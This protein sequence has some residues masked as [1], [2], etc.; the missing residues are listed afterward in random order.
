MT[1][2]LKVKHVPAVGIEA[3]AITPQKIADRTN[4][5]ISE[6]KLWT[7]RRKLKLGQVFEIQEGHQSNWD[8]EILGDTSRIKR[9]GQGMSGGSMLID[10]GAGMHLGNGMKGGSIRVNRNVDSW[11]GCEMVDGSISIGGDA[12]HYIG[13]AYRGSKYG[14]RG[15]SI[16]IEGNAGNEIGCRMS[17]GEI[18]VRGDCMDFSGVNQSGGLIH[19]GGSCQQRPSAGMTGGKLVIEGSVG[20]LIPGASYE[21]LERNLQIPSGPAQG[22]YGVFKSDMA[23][24]SQGKVYISENSN[25]DL[26]DS[27]M[28]S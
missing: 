28:K 9:I 12:G 25:E 21:K 15:G 6:I 3:P 17:G 2:L 23:E 27:Y 13:G 26:L 8:I 5:E 7:G 14:M 18:T 24:S 1:I 20:S 10:G 22:T 19:V 16:E 11:C 4:Q